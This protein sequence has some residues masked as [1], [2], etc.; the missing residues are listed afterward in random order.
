MTPVMLPPGCARL[1]TSPARDRIAARDPNDWYCAGR[2]VGR[3]R[4]GIAADN[5]HVG[6]PVDDLA[7]EVGEA[8]GPPLAGIPLDA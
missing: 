7:S 3:L 1:V 8:L 5:D 2:R 4:D 6:L